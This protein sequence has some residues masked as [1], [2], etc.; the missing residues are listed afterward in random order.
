MES[1][2]KLFGHPVHQIAVEFPIGMLAFTSLT[3]VLHALEPKPVWATA[4]RA[5]LTA[6]IVGAAVAA[7]FGLIDYLA[8]P[9]KTRAKRI[10]AFH[11]LGN[12]G[13]LSLFLGSLLLRRR[14][15]RPASVALSSLAMLGL[16]VTA[17]LGGELIN[18]LG[19]GVY[20]PTSL[21]AKST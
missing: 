13:V 17:W 18:R 15:A 20:S 7:P 12:V 11:A 16:G 2:A 9:R 19:V 14:R 5:A 10:G 6:G 4:G 3:D 1:R 21:N 8:I